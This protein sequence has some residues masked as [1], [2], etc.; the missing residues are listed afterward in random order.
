MTMLY[1]SATLNS[2]LSY[3]EMTSVGV[4]LR[5]LH[6]NYCMY[7]VSGYLVNNRVPGQGQG[8]TKAKAIIHGPCTI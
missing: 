4:E 1:G 5:K 7:V 2:T 3:D 8:G 6:N